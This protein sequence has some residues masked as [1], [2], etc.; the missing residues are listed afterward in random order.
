MVV[1]GISQGSHGWRMESE[2]CVK[3]VKGLPWSYPRERGLSTGWDELYLWVAVQTQPV[4][5]VTPVCYWP[6]TRLCSGSYYC[7]GVGRLRKGDVTGKPSG[8]YSVYQIITA[9]YATHAPLDR[10]AIFIMDQPI[11]HATQ[12]EHA[13]SLQTATGQLGLE[14]P[15]AQCV[16]RLQGHLNSYTSVCNELP[17]PILW[18][19]VW[20]ALCM[21]SSSLW[22]MLP[23]IYLIYEPNRNLLL[24]HQYGSG[25]QDTCHRASMPQDLHG[26][27]ITDTWNCRLTILYAL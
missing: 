9:Q 22:L 19:S 24:G 4:P 27:E 26:A 11:W 2:C 13:T 25:G 20:C 16:P 18:V 6:D 1:W 14:T 10:K 15:S 8:G 17:Y 3:V 21:A 12:P 7:V 5:W 23:C